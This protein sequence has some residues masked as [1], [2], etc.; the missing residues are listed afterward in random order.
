MQVDNRLALRLGT[1]DGQAEQDRV[2]SLSL[3]VDTK[4]AA[5]VCAAALDGLSATVLR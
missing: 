1:D 3:V 2:T 5:L 4:P